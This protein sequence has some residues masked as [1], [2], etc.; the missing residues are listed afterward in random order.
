MLDD[1]YNELKI[2]TNLANDFINLCKILFYG[3]AKENSTTL[4]SF[5]DC[6]FIRNDLN[7][8]LY[9]IENNCLHEFKIL[10]KNHIILNISGILF[11]FIFLIFYSITSYQP[12][13]NEIEEKI[14][15]ILNDEIEKKMKEKS[16]SK[17]GLMNDGHILKNHVY[18]TI[19]YQNQ[20]NEKVEKQNNILQ[21][22]KNDMNLKSTKQ[23]D[24]SNGNIDNSKEIL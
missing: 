1:L 24:V 20:Q 10:Y 22:N 7:F 15:I 3:Y 9:E 19:V 13:I 2:T 4:Y 18:N 8:I 23:N 11:S 5:L 6:D 21:L 17:I 16:A 12:I 14:K